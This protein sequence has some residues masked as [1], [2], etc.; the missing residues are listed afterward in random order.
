VLNTTETLLPGYPVARDVRQDIVSIETNGD[1][2]FLSSK[3][4]R[5][6]YCVH[7]NGPIGDERSSRHL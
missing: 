6:G 1:I 4:R 7:N 5:S 3:K 2:R